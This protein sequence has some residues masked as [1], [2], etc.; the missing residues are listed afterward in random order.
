MSPRK[1]PKGSVSVSANRGWLRLRWSHWGQ[2]YTLAVGL[3]G[4]IVNRRLAELQ[5]QVI[6]KD[7]EADRLT[8][9]AFDPSLAKYR[10]SAASQTVSV[11][12]LFEKYTEH[13]CRTLPDP[14]SLDKYRGLLGHL[15]KYFKTRSSSS[16]GESKAFEFRDWLLKSL[17]PL[18]VRERIG[19]LRSCWD[20]AIQKKLLAENPWS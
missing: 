10:D 8:P 19:M 3:L 2:S 12:K 1:S 7:I 9:G 18:T 5:A 4:T 16:L 13:K 17:K 15:N 6:Q 11:V 20:W 14:R